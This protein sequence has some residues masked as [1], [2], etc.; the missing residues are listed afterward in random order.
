M[1]KFSLRT[2]HLVATTINA[3]VVGRELLVSTC[4]MITTGISVGVEKCVAPM[5]RGN[6]RNHLWP[7]RGSW[8][9]LRLP[10]KRAVY[11]ILVV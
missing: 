8:L 5:W 10:F 4:Y 6:H 3:P 1:I 2:R 9:P 7:H 11:S